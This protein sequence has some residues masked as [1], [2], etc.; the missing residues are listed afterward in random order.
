[1]TIKP[2]KKLG[3][4]FLID[5]QAIKKVISTANI[6]KQDTILEI[7]PGLGALTKE[8]IKKTNKVIA[9]E[10][11]YRLIEALKQKFKIEIINQDIL[12]YKP[13]LK[14]Y[15]I[16]SSLPFYIA[17][18]I[19]KN[20]LET[21]N[22]PQEMIL[23]IQKEVAQRI[24]AEPP[25]MSILAVSVQIY[26]K[27]EIISYIGKESFS[28]IPK[29]D[30]AIIKIIPNRKIVDKN[31]FKIVKV[32][33]SHPRKKLI[34]NLS[35]LFEKEALISTFNRLDLDVNIRAERLNLDDW[36]ALSKMV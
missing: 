16:V 19:I 27:A 17:T 13:N 15:K 10:K 33:F 31:F 29:V 35:T 1:M 2:I 11:D 9:V 6:K 32:G 3:Q 7:G 18:P 34:N 8:L 20:F 28:P 21:E 25:D 24:C 5:K 4:N 22:P 23:I 14:D 12:G 26:A 30:C 36:I